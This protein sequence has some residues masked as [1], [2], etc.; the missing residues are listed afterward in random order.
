[1]DQYLLYICQNALGDIITSLPSIH[2][3]KKN[4]TH[5]DVLL[6]EQFSDLLAFDPHFDSIISFQSE[7]FNSFPDDT[8]NDPKKDQIRSLTK[9][10]D[11]IVDSLCSSS[12]TELI[13]LLNPPIAIGIEFGDELYAYN[14][15]VSIDRWQSWSDGSRNASDCF[16][17]LTRAYCLDYIA[18]QP[19]LYI[20]A[21]AVIWAQ[22]WLREQGI[23]ARNRLVALNPGAGNVAKCWPFE[24]YLELADYLKSK[25]CTV[26]FLFG[27]K[28]TGLFQSHGTSVAQTGAHAIHFSNSLIQKTAGLLR[29][30]SLAISNDCAVMHIAAAIEC[31]TLAI[32][33]P[34]NSKIWF[35]YDRKKNCVVERNVTCRQ[36]CT[37]GCDDPVCLTKISVS[38]VATVALR[39]L[40]TPILPT[41]STAMF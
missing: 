31:P 25:Q 37:K 27:P 34:S 33:G 36:Y 21:D 9:S 13:R 26:I 20:S 24:R 28:E 19:R 32:F 16:A 15:K 3:L 8:A 2:F 5:V 30:C 40:H 23:H 6:N 17:D 22:S 12:T 4:F 10:Y 38:D 14:R 18:T 29:Q 11:V 41:A 39:L 35:P 1:M 7:W